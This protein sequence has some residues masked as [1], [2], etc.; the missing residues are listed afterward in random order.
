MLNLQ[1]TSIRFGFAFVASA[2]KLGKAGLSPAVTVYRNSSAT[3]IATG[4]ATELANGL[5]FYDLSSGL[6]T[7]DGELWAVAITT[8]DTVVSKVSY[9]H[10][11][12]GKAGLPNLDAAI[13]SRTAGSPTWP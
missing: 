2:T 11:L 3:P 12:V 4:T 9:S 6:N 13:T 10:H 8:D 5:Y 7:V 1:N